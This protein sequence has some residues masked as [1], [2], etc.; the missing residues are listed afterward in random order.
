[1]IDVMSRKVRTIEDDVI[2]A[3]QE[4]ELASLIALVRQEGEVEDNIQRLALE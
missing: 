2:E 3:V 4:D 1:M